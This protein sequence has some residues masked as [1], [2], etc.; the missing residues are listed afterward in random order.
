MLELTALYQQDLLGQVS[1]TA[2]LDCYSNFGSKS[3]TG[4]RVKIRNKIKVNLGSGMRAKLMVRLKVW[5]QFQ[6]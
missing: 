6:D 3:G 5:I 4:F 2:V 1:G